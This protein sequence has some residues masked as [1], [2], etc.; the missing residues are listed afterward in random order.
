M[1]SLGLVLLVAAIF[2]CI[3]VALGWNIG[4]LSE[5]R[6]LALV[7]ATGFLGAVLS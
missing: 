4:D 7:A 6:T 5:V 2:G 1:P 3:A